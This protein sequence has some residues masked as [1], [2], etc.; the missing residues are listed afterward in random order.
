MCDSA[1]DLLSCG[2][3]QVSGSNG[4][5][6]VLEVT[7]DDPYN[8]ILRD[9]SKGIDPTT[10]KPAEQG[11]INGSYYGDKGT[12]DVN[13]NM[14]G[15]ADAFVDIFDNDNEQNFGDGTGPIWNKIDIALLNSRDFFELERA[16][17]SL[18]GDDIASLAV[19][20]KSNVTKA[21]E[22]I[23]DHASQ[24]AIQQKLRD[25]LYCDVQSASQEQQKQCMIDNKSYPSRE[26]GA[27]AK[28]NMDRAISPHYSDEDA[29]YNYNRTGFTLGYDRRLS[30]NNTLG[31]A[32]DY[33]DMRSG[34]S[35]AVESHSFAGYIN[36]D[37][38]DDM[39]VNFGLL[40]AFSHLKTQ[41]MVQIRPDLEDGFN[42]MIH[43]KTR[44]YS[45]GLNAELGKNIGMNDRH[46]ISP[47]VGMH[48]GHELT[49][50]YRE[51]DVTINPVQNADQVI[52]LIFDRK[53]YNYADVRLGAR[54]T[55]IVPGAE[56]A[57][58]SADIS[59]IQPVFSRTPSVKSQ[60]VGDPEHGWIL[61]GKKDQ[62]GYAKFMTSVEYPWSDRFSFSGK[63]GAKIGQ[64]SSGSYHGSLGFRWFY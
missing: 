62:Y 56:K 14:L 4:Q 43:G 31:I 52:P 34:R 11:S 57:T 50:A 22:N 20:Q 61:K 44:S 9:L 55:Q 8:T 5:A 28:F 23:F 53:N 54:F 17:K 15:V 26:N 64:R 36:H 10:G 33:G 19:V 21:S 59:W 18:S 37:M 35:I 51:H 49:K 47:Y 30:P 1:T 24:L 46:W 58:I 38:D 40:G 48:V 27:W 2:Q 13:D 60:F 3:S 25:T 29:H 7:R 6:M 42:N 39:Y 32:W 45:L 63:L 12:I 16:F 41:R